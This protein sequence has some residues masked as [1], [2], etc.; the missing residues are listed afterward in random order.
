MLLLRGRFALAS[1]VGLANTFD[2]VAMVPNDDVCGPVAR[3]GA[4]TLVFRSGGARVLT[5]GR[6]S[7]LAVAAPL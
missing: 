1:R 3:S 5:L 6:C 2:A 4:A 7:V